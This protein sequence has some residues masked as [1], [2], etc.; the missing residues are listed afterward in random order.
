MLRPSAAAPLGVSRRALDCDQEAREN[1]ITNQVPA[2]ALESLGLRF[3]HRRCHAAAEGRAA[4]DAAAEGR[5]AASDA[6]AGGRW[7]EQARVIAMKKLERV[8]S[9]GKFLLS[10]KHH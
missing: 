1:R 4:S 9:E 8:A 6:A 3:W 10:H 2:V 5:G 7:G